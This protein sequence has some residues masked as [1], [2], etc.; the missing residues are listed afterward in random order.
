MGR[1]ASTQLL[2]FRAWQL[3]LQSC[4]LLQSEISEATFMVAIHALLC[5]YQDGKV[6]VTLKIIYFCTDVV[7][8]FHVLPFVHF[9]ILSYS[10]LSLFNYEIG[11]LTHGGQTGLK[12][13]YHN[14]LEIREDIEILLLPHEG[15]K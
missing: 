9:S 6:M 7:P 13:K 12:M 4:T 14:K 5:I 8:S 3:D 2:D 10:R 15:L 11:S 1:M